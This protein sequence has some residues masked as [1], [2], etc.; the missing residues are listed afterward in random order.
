ME[1]QE[2]LKLEIGTTEQ[3]VK[4]LKPAKVKI[5]KVTI[6]DIEKVKSKKAVFEIKHPEAEN[7][8]K[9]SAVSFLDGKIVRTVGTW[10]NTD[11]EGKL[12]K[13]T[14]L[15]TFLKELNVVSLNG[16]VGLEAETEADDAGYLVFKAY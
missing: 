14:G 12:Q 3:E 6:E 7:T 15:T 1:E 2:I 5:V 9:I 11:K 13:G 4:K 8:I 10:I 16:T